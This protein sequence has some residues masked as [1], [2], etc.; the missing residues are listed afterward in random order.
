MRKLLKFLF[1]AG[2]WCVTL[3]L[4]WF[5]LVALMVTSAMLWSVIRGMV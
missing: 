2:V 5:G 3:S 1:W 4:L